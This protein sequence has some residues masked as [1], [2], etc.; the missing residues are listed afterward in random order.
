MIMRISWKFLLISISNKE[1][2][3]N[4]L[5]KT[6][7]SSTSRYLDLPLIMF[8]LDVVQK[9]DVYID[10][11]TGFIGF[12]NIQEI[13]QLLHIHLYE[14]TITHYCHLNWSPFP[15]QLL[16]AHFNLIG[17]W[18]SSGPFRKNTTTPSFSMT[19]FH[20]NNCKMVTI[21]NLIGT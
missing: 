14:H 6:L 15:Y 10:L 11:S 12:V 2:S 3:Q 7:T 8:D 1:I 16:I 13:P 5:V 21:L 17:S 19:T 20:A 18:L 9:I 4:Y